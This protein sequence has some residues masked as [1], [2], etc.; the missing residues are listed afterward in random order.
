MSGNSA[1]SGLTKR[2]R[3]EL[4][5]AQA[6]ERREAERR[7]RRRNRLLGQGGAV[8]GLLAVV[9]LVCWN[10]WSQQEV[11][12][13]GPAN[14]LSDGI[15]LAGDG[16]AVTA[17]TTAAIAPG[18]SPVP[19]DESATRAGGVVAV[20]LYVDYLCPYCGQFEKANAEQL[21]SWLTKG[22]ITLEIHPIAILDSS[23]AGS[24]YSSRAANAAAC[25]AD[26]DPDS[27]LAV[28]A[29][30]FAQQPAEGTTGL[31]DDALRALVTGA[32]VTDDDVL[33]CMTAGEFRPWVKAATQRAT[34]QP[35]ANSSLEKL[36]STPTVLVNGEQY[37]GKPDDAAA[38]VSF[39]TSTLEAESA[40]P[41]PSP[42]PA[43]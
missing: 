37:T 12:S 41:S 1:R 38:F 17:T 18:A 13:A 36:E 19:T 11:A 23:S 6:R 24:E 3:Q 34:T 9:A 25:V 7:R 33:A 20:D 2:E 5:R 14:M 40:T 27:F 30:L 42:S 31:D 4:A 15:V 32:G 39:V 43:G 21:Q 8:V 10:V 29:A 22:A 26:E 16:S 35:L 28:N